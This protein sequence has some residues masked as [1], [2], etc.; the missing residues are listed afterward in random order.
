MLSPQALFRGLVARLLPTRNVDS[1]S[2]D[3]AARMG[4][5]GEVDVLSYVRKAHL[6]ADEGSY[7]VTTNGQAGISAGNANNTFTATAPFMVIENLDQAGGKSVNLDYINLITTVAAN[8]AAGALTYIGIIGIIDQ[9]LRYTSGGTALPT[10]V[11][12][13]MNIIAARS[14]TAA[15]FGVITASGQTAS[16]RQVC[17]MRLFRACNNNVGDAVGEQK[18]INF[19]GVEGIAPTSYGGNANAV[20]CLEIPMPPVIIG[21]QQSALFYLYSAG[22]NTNTPGNFIPDIG[23]F[24]R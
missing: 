3:V 23:V 11:C 8:S 22:N 24:E 15:Y 14:V 18:F 1:Q 17:G 5:Y 12:P 9:G 13:N 20:N 7:F 16:A 2:S 6:L 4:P 21:P 10:P 19:G